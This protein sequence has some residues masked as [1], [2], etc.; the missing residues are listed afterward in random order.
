MKIIYR[1]K[2]LILTVSIFGI[3]GI[4][5]KILQPEPKPASDL[6][7]IKK[8][9]DIFHDVYSKVEELYVD[10]PE[11][12]KLM[13]KGIDAMLASLD[14]YTN[15]IPESKME[16]YRFMSTGAYGGIGALIGSY[17]G[18]I[19]ISEIYEG[20]PAHIGGLMAGDIIKEI[21][22][23]SVEN[24]SQSDISEFLK[25]Q[26][27]TEVEI[28]VKRE[29]TDELI[30]TTLIRKKVKIPDVP[31]YTIIEDKVGYVK[32]NSFT[33]T[34]ASEVMDAYSDL[35]NQ[36]MEKFILDLRGNG[37]GL[38]IEAVK[39]VNMFVEKGQEV[40]S[41]RGRI[42]N[43][44]KIYQ[45]LDRPVDLAIPL[46]VIVDEGSAS[47]SE[48]VSGSLQDLD[49]AVIVGTRT[50]G[51]GLVQ[52]TRDIKYNSKI[53]ITIAKYYT[54]S[55][56][57]IQKLDYSNKENGQATKVPDSL[58][59]EFKTKNGRP[60]FD[61]NGIEPDI[62]IEP[63][64]YSNL[65]VALISKRIIFSYATLY[66]LNNDSIGPAKQFKLTEEDFK[67]FKSFVLK[68]DF[69]YINKSLKQL[70][71]LK[72]VSENEKYT[73][74]IQNELKILEQKLTPQLSV[75]IDRFKDKILLTLENEI[76]SRYYYQKGRMVNALKEDI[77][78]KEAIKILNMR[79]DY[80][81]VLGNP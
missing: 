67:D 43:T 12:G 63:E 55:G 61:G 11:P 20:N 72:E 52:Q 24:K 77:F 37:G 62:T 49:R 30:K 9:L 21:D 47:A 64:V 57:C 46:V 76:I 68:Q 81:R 33:Q 7:E 71:I 31:Y 70:E 29:G 38:L 28:K 18:D 27:D 3:T 39:I 78:L 42:E 25:G 50:Y 45:T 13:L 16:D 35:V 32:L 60:V 40:V 14:P 1:Y 17:K 59:T 8:N 51:K 66:R 65:L 79:S 74:D 15:F 26:P 69:E 80:N 2:W 58:I 44:N 6:F 4:S 34:A 54:P 75:D 56:R 5:W 19:I 41:M 48:I 73:E 53:K 22:G 10:E 23:K 36:G